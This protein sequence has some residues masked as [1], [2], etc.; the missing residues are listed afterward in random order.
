MFRRIWGLTTALILMFFI[1][2]V[3]YAVFSYLYPPAGKPV[4][5]VM[6]QFTDRQAGEEVFIQP[7]CIVRLEKEYACGDVLAE[8]QGPA[9]EGLVGLT[10]QQVQQK[11][12]PSNGW[13][14][15]KISAGMIVLTQKVDR[16][17]ERHRQYRHLGVYDGMVAVYEGPLG[18]NK[19]LLRVE[20]SLPLD[21]LP[22]SMKVKLRQVM[23][24]ERQTDATKRSLREQFE[25][26]NEQAF[27]AALDS[28]D[29]LR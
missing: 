14:M 25:F 19:S 29:E 2:G 11:Y 13:H 27:N 10:K 7:G 6:Q 12:P 3:T 26:P 15:Q 9:P 17:C 20:K 21:K 28:L 16:L 18:Y 4:S 1:A 8:F 24:Y 22:P 23:D 5:I